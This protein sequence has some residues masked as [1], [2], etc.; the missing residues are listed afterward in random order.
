MEYDDPDYSSTMTQHLNPDLAVLKTFKASKLIR[1]FPF[2]PFPT[3]SPCLQLNP[4]S[5]IED[6]QLVDKTYKSLN[7]K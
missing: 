2:E 3:Q 4:L 1:I 6:G 7:Q 5:P